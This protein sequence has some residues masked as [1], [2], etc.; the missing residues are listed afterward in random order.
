[1]QGLGDFS[2]RA[3]VLSLFKPSTRVGYWTLIIG[4]WTL[5][6]D[7]WILV[8]EQRLLDIGY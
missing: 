2:T 8:I 3:I 7:Y 6:R 5:N 4:Y 1:M